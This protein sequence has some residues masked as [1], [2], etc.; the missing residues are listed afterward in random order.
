MKISLVSITK[1]PPTASVHVK[2]MSGD[3]IWIGTL[4][5]E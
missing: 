5:T 4:D 2:E 3:E 1:V